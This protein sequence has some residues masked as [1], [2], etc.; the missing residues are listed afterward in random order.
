MQ[1]AKISG[2]INDDIEMDE[3]DLNAI[4]AVLG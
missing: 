2:E 3:E 4:T 1:D